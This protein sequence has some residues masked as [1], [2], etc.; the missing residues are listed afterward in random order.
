M[1]G[2]IRILKGYQNAKIINFF[3][4]RMEFSENDERF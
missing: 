4:G 3:L 2:I 1:K